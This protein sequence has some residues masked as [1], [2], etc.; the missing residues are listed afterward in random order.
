M[1]R[2]PLHI[3]GT[4]SQGSSGSEWGEQNRYNPVT[5]ADADADVGA[6]A[7][8]PLRSPQQPAAAA[9]AAPATAAATATDFGVPSTT[10]GQKRKPTA[11]LTESAGPSPARRG[12]AARRRQAAMGSS[13][14]S[15]SAPGPS[16]Q[17]V[18][19]ASTR[20]S[21]PSLAPIPTFPI[22]QEFPTQPNTGPVFMSLS[23]SSPPRVSYKRSGI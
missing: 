1:L 18:R 21:S 9:A 6:A 8:F 5:D 10:V 14:R 2:T 22:S 12:A 15:A 20:T 3:T 11:A 19:E 13:P 17:T 7:A 4:T 16:G 23:C